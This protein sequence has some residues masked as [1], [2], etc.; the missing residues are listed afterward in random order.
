V[1]DRWASEFLAETYPDFPVFVR[2]SGI[3]LF[4]M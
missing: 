2:I 4:F 3:L 1:T